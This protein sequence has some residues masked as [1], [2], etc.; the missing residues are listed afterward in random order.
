MFNRKGSDLFIDYT[1]TCTSKNGKCADFQ[2][3]VTIKGRYGID[4]FEQ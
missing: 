3:P 1:K 4:N 2:L